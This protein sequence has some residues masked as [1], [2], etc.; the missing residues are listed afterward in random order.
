MIRGTKATFI[1]MDEMDE[2]LTKEIMNGTSLPEYQLS[3]NEKSMRDALSKVTRLP[4]RWPPCESYK[5]STRRCSPSK[6]HP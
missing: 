3:F 4:N 5:E 2:E 6:V 1:I